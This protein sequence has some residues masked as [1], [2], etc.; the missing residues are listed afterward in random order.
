MKKF[1]EKHFNQKAQLFG[2][3]FLAGDHLNGLSFHSTQH[4][5]QRVSKGWKNEIILDAGCGNGILTH[6]LTSLNYVVGLDFS[7]PMLYLAKKKG[8]IVVRGDALYLPFK[9]NVFSKV[10]AIGLIQYLE[11]LEAVLKE[12]VRVLKPGG[13]IIL[14]FLNRKSFLR[15][16][17]PEAL[18]LRMYSFNEVKEILQRLGIRNF[19]CRSQIYPFPFSLPWC[20]SIL[21]TTWLIKG[22]KID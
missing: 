7:L 13:E 14:T 6:S 2:F 18:P 9:K 15:K 10:L 22:K 11:N 8:L 19:S 16:I 5:I 21:V 4:V 12:L 20:P 3:S 1:W 17:I